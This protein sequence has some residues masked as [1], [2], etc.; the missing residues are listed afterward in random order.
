M[1]EGHCR[2]W[3]SRSVFGRGRRRGGSS[4]A[5]VS[6]P[7]CRCH[8]RFTRS[9]SDSC[10]RK[11]KTECRISGHLVL[12]GFNSMLG[13]TSCPVSRVCLLR[14]DECLLNDWVAVST[15]PSAAALSATATSITRHGQS[16]RRLL[17]SATCTQRSPWRHDSIC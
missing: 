2:T 3:S 7:L 16:D 5:L 13:T 11:P 4:L 15:P 17:R 12:M 9:S 8:R 6:L 10:N 14:L 1:A